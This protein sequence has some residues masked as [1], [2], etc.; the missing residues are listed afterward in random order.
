MLAPLAQVATNCEVA[1]KMARVLMIAGMVAAAEVKR[2][3]A[4][5]IASYRIL[6]AHNACEHFFWYQS[7]YLQSKEDTEA[8]SECCARWGWAVPNAAAIAAIVD[9]AEAGNCRTIF[10]FG[11]G[12]HVAL[13]VSACSVVYSSFTR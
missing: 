4:R 6:V 12:R 10:D 3:L 9:T 13:R 11:A 8:R 2:L 5:L 1:R 7:I